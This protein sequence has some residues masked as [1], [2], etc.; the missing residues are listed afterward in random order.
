MDIDPR[1]MRARDAYRMFVTIVTPRPIAWVSTVDKRGINNLAPFSM[2]TLLSSMPPVAGFGVGAYRDGRQKDTIRNIRANREFVI[3]VVTEDVAAAMNI[4]SAPFPPE[5][6]EF[7]RA[8]LTPAKSRLVAPAR[9][10]ES[11]VNMECRLL[12]VLEFGT[13]PVVNNFVIGEVLL[14]H[15]KDDLWVDGAIDA[16]RLKTVGRLGGGTDLYCRTTDTFELK[17]PETGV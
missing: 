8:S 11:P 17:R 15:V 3:N 13:P 12:Q 5:V 10:A 4:T 9:V 1:T 6:S 14:V 7:D 16:A 2:Y